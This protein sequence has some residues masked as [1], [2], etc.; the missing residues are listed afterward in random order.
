MNNIIANNERREVI[1]LE[2]CQRCHKVFSEEIIVTH[3]GKDKKPRDC[4]ELGF[5]YPLRYYR[6]P[7]CK[8]RYVLMLRDAKYHYF[9]GILPY[10]EEEYRQGDY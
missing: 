4:K 9:Y 3:G 1:S 7:H 5:A 8:A 6:C 10:N 2:T